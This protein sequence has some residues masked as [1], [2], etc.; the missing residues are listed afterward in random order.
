MPTVK[1]E[2]VVD[3]WSILIRNAQGRAGYIFGNTGNAIDQSDVPSVGVVKRKISP[4]LLKGLLGA[5]RDFMVVTETGNRKLKPYQMF[6]GARDYGNNLDVSWYLTYRLTFWQ[7]LRAFFRALPLIGL[8]FIGGEP[9]DFEKGL[10]NLDFF[11]EQDLRAYTTNV[12]GCLKETVEKLLAELGQDPSKINWKS[13][14][15]LGIS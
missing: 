9:I 10:P 7:R 11:D 6:I 5:T 13:R 15:F 8:L 14:G 4:G 3:K 2:Q 1:N 12:H